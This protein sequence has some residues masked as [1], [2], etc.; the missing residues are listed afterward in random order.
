MRK[1]LSDSYT[2]GLAYLPTDVTSTSHN[3]ASVQIIWEKDFQRAEA[4][5]VVRG[6][7][8][9]YRNKTKKYKNQSRK[10]RTF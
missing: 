9:K 4:P 3:D 6:G 10:S 1:K 2:M 5:P 7:S 8:R